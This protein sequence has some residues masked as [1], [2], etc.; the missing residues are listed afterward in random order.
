V[1]TGSTGRRWAPPTLLLGGAGILLGRTIALLAG[2]ARRVLRPWVVAL[3]WIEM[4]IDALTMAGALRWLRSGD[5]RH[6]RL[7]MRAGA[8]ATLLHAGRVAVFVL[9]RTGPWRD[10][11][12]RTEARADHG[13]RWT[14][15]QV[16]FAGT[17]SVSGIVGVVL[18]WRRRR[19]AAPMAASIAARH[20]SIAA[21]STNEVHA[22]T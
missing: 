14:W 16:V 20:S 12:V 7:P 13:E 19:Q 17:L 5:P 18:I 3:T 9:G 10:F 15:G 6:A 8:A 1:R 4:A 22:R 21:S 11:D 2:G